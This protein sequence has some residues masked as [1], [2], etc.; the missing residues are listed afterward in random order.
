MET[1]SKSLALSAGNSR[2]TGEFSSQRPVTRSFAVLFDLRLN[3][4]LS[5]QWDAGDLRRHHARCGVTVMYAL[6]ERQWHHQPNVWFCLLMLNY[7]F[8]NNSLVYALYLISFLK[9]IVSIDSYQ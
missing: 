3:K 6:C 2:V 1:F 4:R 7:N 5:K 9:T 8:R